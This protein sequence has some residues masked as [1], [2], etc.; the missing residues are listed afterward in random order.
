MSRHI[1]QASGVGWRR[2]N[3]CVPFEHPFL[4]QGKGKQHCALGKHWSVLCSFLVN[5]CSGDQKWKGKDRDT[6]SSECESQFEAP[7]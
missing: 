6:L 4:A 7:N 5:K 2:V 3:L 1:C